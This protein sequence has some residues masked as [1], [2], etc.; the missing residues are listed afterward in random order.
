MPGLLTDLRND[1][2]PLE[3]RAIKVGPVSW[4]D[5]PGRQKKRYTSNSTLFYNIITHEV[6]VTSEGILI[7]VKEGRNQEQSSTQYIYAYGI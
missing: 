4:M 3:Q 2:P 7:L 6:N 1:Q 5:R